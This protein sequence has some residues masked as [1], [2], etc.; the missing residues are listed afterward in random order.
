VHYVIKE[1][2]C[3]KFPETS[4]LWRVGGGGGTAQGQ[5]ELVRKSRLRLSRALMDGDGQFLAFSV[6][7]KVNTTC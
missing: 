7:L 4:P 5:I 2:F 6:A 3:R 1:S